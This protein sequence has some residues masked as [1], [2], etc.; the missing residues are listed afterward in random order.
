[1]DACE[2]EHG[3]YVETRLD[4]WGANVGRI[5]AYKWELAP[6]AIQ[7]TG[8]LSGVEAAR[9]LDFGYSSF[10]VKRAREGTLYLDKTLLPG[11]GLLFRTDIGMQ[12]YPRKK[13]FDALF[14][15]IQDFLQPL[16]I[17]FRIATET[18]PGEEEPLT[19]A[20]L[21]NIR[22]MAL[23]IKGFCPATCSRDADNN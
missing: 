20:P 4:L 10:R 16:T 8:A 13:T 21:L 1:V 3:V 15:A 11:C 12:I 9:R 5:A 7:Y 17:T 2:N 18:S 23:A 6:R 22:Q 14:Y 19:L